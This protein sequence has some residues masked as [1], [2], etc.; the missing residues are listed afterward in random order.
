[1]S[2]SPKGPR[3]LRV[4]TL[5][6]LLLPLRLAAADPCDFASSGAVA[7]PWDQVVAC[8]ETVPFHHD[9]LENILAVI[10]QDRS[11]SDLA[12][13]YDAR[14][15]WVASLSA[16]DD[17]TTE[18]D[19]LGD[20]AM[21]NAIK[22]E[23]KNL[24]NSHVTYVAPQCY[25]NMLIAFVPF[26][27]GVTTR[28][29]EPAEKQIVFIEDAS[30]GSDLYQL[31]T[32]ID[33]AELV[34]MKV[35]AINGTP[36]LEYFR[37]FGREQLK[38][39]DN[40]GSNLS[41]I[42]NRLDYSLRASAEHAFIPDRGADE[43]LLES[44]NGR[45]FTVTLP[46][47]FAWRGLLSP[48]L[49][50]TA[51]TEEFIELCMEPFPP[52]S[53]AES[54]ESL[55]KSW[56][57]GDPPNR[58]Q[59]WFVKTKAS[60]PEVTAKD[61][62][63]VPPGQVGKHIEV[64]FP[65]ADGAEVLQY[66]NHVTAIRLAH[67][68]DWID[69]VRAGIEHACQNS[70]RLIID[71]RGNGGGGDV[72]IRWLHQHLFPEEEDLAQAG[73]IP[74]RV[75]NDNAKL[76]EYLFKV[77]LFQSLA[78]PMGFPPCVDVLTGQIPL[79]G[80]MCWMDLESGEP[81]PLSDLDW[82][83]SP[84]ITE[85]RAGVPV[86]LSRQVGHSQLLSRTFPEFDASSCAGRFAGENLIFLTD[87]TNGS[88][89]YTLPAAFK[90]EGVIATMGGFVDEPIAMGR[91]RSGSKGQAWLWA[92]VVDFIEGLTGGFISFDE[93]Y[94]QFERNVT[95]SMEVWG[96]Y[97]KD[98]TTLHFDEPVEADLHLHVWSDSFETHGYVYGRLLEAVD[99]ADRKPVPQS[100]G[101]SN[102]SQHFQLKGLTTA[103]LPKGH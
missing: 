87:G 76:N 55:E 12:E 38:R 80:P 96:A 77:A 67:T 54:I 78:V 37:A 18:E 61:F 25:W 16:L 86:S 17:P 48:S 60:G 28:F 8:Y 91:A 10:A 70:E 83:L 51:S 45:R 9:D 81:L 79:W 97:R 7:F 29:L 19:Y 11:F 30:I 68:D 21:H 101:S 88:G 99:A 84:S 52:L 53:S 75:R 74:F 31:A 65:Q 41:S 103:E 73:K 59:S 3:F 33:A 42:L 72:A 82:F 6:F 62:F 57:R 34:G 69:E 27:F 56:R 63:E 95:S 22:A 58:E 89:G 92:S 26:D 93:E 46:W 4:A 49:P 13:L 50:L 71:L 20:F 5:A 100:H 35:V 14:S 39:D 94:V 66:K 23:H 64:I 40:D 47:V 36:A 44:R 102:P 32:G 2:A 43:Y 15:G 24:L 1:M 98:R 90:G 85:L